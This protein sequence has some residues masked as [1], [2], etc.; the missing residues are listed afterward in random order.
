MARSPQQFDD[1]VDEITAL[2]GRRGEHGA[3]VAE[4]GGMFFPRKVPLIV[5]RI[6]IMRRSRL[7]WLLLKCTPGCSKK[8]IISS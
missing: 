6:F 3:Q 1:G 5:F 8:P 7:A 2:P 4:G